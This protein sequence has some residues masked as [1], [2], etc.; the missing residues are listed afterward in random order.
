MLLPVAPASRCRRFLATLLLLCPG[1]MVGQD[2]LTSP[3]PEKALEAREPQSKLAISP[4]GAA[5]LILQQGNTFRVVELPSG[6]LLRQ[7]G[8]VQGKI[9]AL[10]LA[11]VVGPVFV[12]TEK[13]IWSA[14]ADKDDAPRRLWRSEAVIHDLALSPDLDLLAVGTSKGARVLNPASG[15]T[16]WSASVWTG[17]GKPCHAT[18]FAPVGGTLALGIGSTV[19][20]HA[21]PGFKLK[22]SWSLNHPVLALAFAPDARSLAV[23]GGKGSLL[24]KRVPDGETLKYLNTDFAGGDVTQVSFGFDSSGLAAAAGRRL[25]AFSGLDET[26]PVSKLVPVEANILSLAFSKPAG[27]MFAALDGGAALA[28]WSVVNPLRAG[29]PRRDL[30]WLSILSPANGTQIAADSVELTFRVGFPADQAV[31]AIRVFADG[32]PAR[33]SAP[34]TSGTD[35][36]ILAGTFTSGQI[37]TCR[38]ELP[39]RDTTLMLVAEGPRGSSEPAL[40]GLQR[41]AARPKGNAKVVPPTITLVAPGSEA[42]LQSTALNLVV[43]VNSVPG[44]PVQVVRV[45]LD[46]VPVPLRE[47]LQASGVPFDPATGWVS[48][49]NYRLPIQVPERD[50]T[51]MV[52]AE[53]AYASSNPAVAKLRWRIP[54]SGPVA[55]ASAGTE[56]S[57]AKSAEETGNGTVKATAES[58]RI[59]EGG[60]QGAALPMEVDAKGRLRWKEKTPDASKKATLR[61]TAAPAVPT[62]ARAASPGQPTVQVLSPADGARFKDRTVQ[63]SL[64]LGSPKGQDVNRLQVFVDGSPAEATPQAADGSPLNPPYPVGQAFKLRVAVPFQD[65][66]VTVVA[67][68]AAS[69]S[70]PSLLRLKYDGKPAAGMSTRSVSQ[71]AKPKVAIFEPQPNALVRGKAVQI[72]VRVG[73]DPRQPPPAIRFL[74]DAQEVKAERAVPQ[75]GVATAPQPANDRG[76][77]EEIQYYNVPIPAKDCTVVAYAETSYATSDPA[78]VKLRFDSPNLASTATGIPTLYLLSVGVSK[79]KD[80]NF[81]LT[82]PAKDA[83][84]FAETMKLQKGKLYKDVVAR[85]RTDETATRDNVM[86]DL[87]WIQ[88]Q[89]TQRDVV[90]VFFAGHGINDVVTGNYY[91]LPHDANMEAVKRTMIPGSEIHSTLARLTGTRLLF[92]DTCHAGNVTGTATRGLPD[93]QQFLQDLKE[94]GQGLVVITS[95]RPGQKSQEH[96]SWN[97]GAFTKALVEGLR[98]MAP[99]DKQGFVTFTALD[100]YITQRVKELTKGTQA[101]A[102]QKGTEISDFPLAYSGN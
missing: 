51:L 15:A 21:V 14:P 1:V 12:A 35:A 3:T 102:S 84:D 41:T 90:I 19:Q 64:K 31:T 16:E 10:A 53:T 72:G 11:G 61:G 47:V 33:I 79:Y 59:L 40:V 83:R 13:E 2:L 4:D 54:T 39:E 77:T 56:E 81:T 49:E 89:A 82:Y 101:P 69:Q 86:D 88:R 48:G 74:V 43:R 99:K 58:T 93:M 37:L 23:G 38:I 70:R 95:S 9:T 63:L 71:L 73:L 98:G 46:G 66:Q 6:R 18:R 36:G 8:P 100:A 26:T 80:R 60:P 28:R 45:T 5:A 92:M 29:R 32:R 87:E 27:A 25:Q 22:Q 52:I 85:I 24:V 67:E 7:F 17:S 55:A 30:P 44:Q 57:P 42:S 94:G 91:Y 78:L 76:G 75:R 34:S 20:I 65:C 97:N 50:G 62:P 68:N 96:P